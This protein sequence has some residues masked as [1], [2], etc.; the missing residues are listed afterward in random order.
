MEKNATNKAFTIAKKDPQWITQD[1]NVLMEKINGL[2]IHR[3]PAIEDERGELV[4]IYRPTWGI[5]DEPMAYAYFLLM[6][7][8]VIKGWVIHELQD[9]RIFVMGGVQRWVF[10]D[11]RPDSTT[12]KNLVSVTIS[13]RNRAL[14]IIPK[15][16]F[17][18]VQNLGTTEATYF[19]IPTKE[20]DRDNPDKF[21]LP[22]KNDLIPFNFDLE[23]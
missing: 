12:Y 22:L 13:E 9:D 5:S 6:R 8:K 18:A 7:P 19:N 14:I 3:T 1:G 11:N 4:E 10:F 2:I 17:H 23:G 20:Y 15:G 21:R 16:V